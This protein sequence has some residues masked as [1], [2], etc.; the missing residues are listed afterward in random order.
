MSSTHSR[1]ISVRSILTIDRRNGRKR[2]MSSNHLEAGHDLV[3]HS[4]FSDRESGDDSSSLDELNDTSDEINESL[5]D[6][7]QGLA[8]NYERNYTDHL[9]EFKLEDN[10][11]YD[12]AELVD[13]DYRN[14]DREFDGEGGFNNNPQQLSDFTTDQLLERIN[15]AIQREDNRKYDEEE[16]LE[17]FN[18]HMDYLESDHQ[19]ARDELMQQQA[20]EMNKTIKRLRKK[21]KTQVEELKLIQ[22]QRIRELVVSREEEMVE[23]ENYYS[24]N[25]RRKVEMKEELNSRLSSILPNPTSFI[26]ECYICLEAMKPPLQILNCRN[27]H[28]ICSTCYP[29]L[30]VKVCG[31][32]NGDITG[33][34]TAMEQ[35]V[36]QILDVQ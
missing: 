32:C 9:N 14:P 25:K 7:D 28:L 36:R 24:Q 3:G 10:H 4:N 29:M 22:S 11:A 16:Q 1:G 31:Q 26:P 20:K 17:R 6:L 13:S 8:D 23:N 12:D 27:G 34:A 33:K 5:E 30:Q 2:L 19:R 18:E 35:I 15:E 21:H